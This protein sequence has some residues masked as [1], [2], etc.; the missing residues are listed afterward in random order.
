MI[1]IFI[2][3]QSQ[4]FAIP[5]IPPK[6]HIFSNSFVR[7]VSRAGNLKMEERC[8]EIAIWTDEFGVS[9]DIKFASGQWASKDLKVVCFDLTIRRSLPFLPHPHTHPSTPHT[10]IHCIIDVPT[11]ALQA[12]LLTS[13]RASICCNV[14]ACRDILDYLIAEQA[15]AS[16][17][18]R[19]NRNTHVQP[20]A[21]YGVLESWLHSL[22]GGVRP[23][24]SS[25]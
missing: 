9:W 16:V 23:W 13:L 24:S 6:K 21:N 2:F 18:S 20:L 12:R 11:T 14:G 3:Q 8:L 25:L 7:I 5:K 22:L 1:Y 10:Q 15:H 19:R 4:I 17:H